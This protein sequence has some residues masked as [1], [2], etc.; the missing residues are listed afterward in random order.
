MTGMKEAIDS[1]IAM[2]MLMAAFFGAAFVCVIYG[3]YWIASHIYWE[4]I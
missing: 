1:A 4:W 3:I 2:L